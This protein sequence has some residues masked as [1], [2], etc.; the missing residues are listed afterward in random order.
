MVTYND[1]EQA[2]I[3][4]FNRFTPNANSNKSK[5]EQYMDSLPDEKIRYKCYNC[6]HIINKLDLNNGKCPVCGDKDM[7]VRT[8]ILD[9]N[10]CGHDITGCIEYC[11]V[12]GEPVCPKCGD[13]NVLAISRITGYMQDISGFNRAKRCEHRDRIRSELNA[14]GEMVISKNTC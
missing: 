14:V 12:C 11:P 1:K 8:C 2:I 3:D 10:G 4:Q 7:L 5:Y 6:F 9:H 13:H